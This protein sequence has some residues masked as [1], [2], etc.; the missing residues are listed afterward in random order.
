MNN[1]LWVFIGGGLGSVVRYAMSLGVLKFVEK[2]VFPWA[3]FMANMLACIV[4]GFLMKY[5]LNHPKDQWLRFFL[6]VGF[7]GGFSTFST[8]SYENMVLFK[9]GFMY[10]A[11]TNIIVSLLFGILLVYLSSKQLN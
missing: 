10:T 9:D 4:L 7:C 3:T 1:W 8:F 6:I 5:G 2:P 11:I